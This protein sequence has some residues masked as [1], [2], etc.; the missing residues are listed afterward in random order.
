MLFVRNNDRPGLIGGLG[1]ILG[2]AGINIASFHLG[3]KSEG[4]DAIALVSI[5]QALSDPLLSTICD[6]P[7]V[8][9]VKAL[10][11]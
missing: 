11:F 2:D 3:R 4:G 7:N 9:Q 6:L 8:V 10:Q 1:T 5:D